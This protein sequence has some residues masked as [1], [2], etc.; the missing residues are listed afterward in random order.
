M[1]DEIETVNKATIESFIVNNYA[2]NQIEAHL[3]RFNPIK[4]MKMENM[5]SSKHLI[6]LF[7]IALL[8]F[9]YS[10]LGEA[11]EIIVNQSCTL[12]DAIHAANTDSVFGNCSAGDGGDVITMENQ[13]T[14]I[15]VNVGLFA[16]VIQSGVMTAFPPITSEVTINGNGLQ[17]LADSSKNHFRVFEFFHTSN[18]RLIL[19][20]VTIFGANEGSGT[21]SALFSMG[22]NL[23]LKNC[24]FEQNHGAV[25]LLE[26]LDAIIE[27]T[28]FVNNWAD[29]GEQFSPALELIGVSLTMK[30]N[31]L[32]NNQVNIISNSVIISDQQPGGAVSITSPF[33]GPIK[34]YNNTISGNQAVTGGGVSIRDQSQLF[35]LQGIPAPVEL[36]FNTITNNTALFA[37]GVAIHDVN[38]LVKFSH[39]LIVG[40]VA[41][42]DEGRE[43]WLTVSSDLEMDDYNVIGMH[44]FTTAFVDVFGNDDMLTSQLPEEVFGSLQQL[45]QWWYHPLLAGSDAI[46]VGTSDCFLSTD[47][48]NQPRLI[49]GD[50]DGQSFC[51]AGSYEFQDIIF[52][53]GFE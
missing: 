47:Q 7:W 44:L 36:R 43:V 8:N 25:L 39:N 51:D 13:D 16:S 38:S 27:D 52:N 12:V 34:M 35:S 32:I 42:E 23:T 49:D 9:Y 2:L 19:N 26:T 33:S 28:V 6:I 4:I 53:D 46:D 18:Q 11:A 50:A 14:T 48:L 41:A 10:T 37:G 5:K 1:N 24:Q 31:S 45:N 40:N 3:N 15:E 21:G 29:Q 17:V 20:G 30:R 22:G